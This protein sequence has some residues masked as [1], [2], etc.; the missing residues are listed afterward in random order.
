M[1][2]LLMIVS[3]ACTI[4]LANGSEHATG[5][6]AEE[7]LAPYERFVSAGA[8]LVIATPD[9]RPPQPDPWGLEPFFHY[10]QDDEDFMF[11]VFRSFAPDADDIRVTFTHFSELNLVVLRRVFLALVDAGL[12]RRAARQV[13]ESAAQRSWRAGSDFIDVL[14]DVREVTERLSPHRIRA[15]RD[16]VWGESSANAERAASVLAGIPGLQHPRRLDELTEEEILSCDGVFI[17]GG[18]AP[19]VDLADNPSMGRVL[20]LLHDAGKTIAALC[21]GPAALLSAPDSDG[22]WLFDGYKMTAFT[23][24]EEDQTQAGRTG[25]PWY[26]EDA[27]KN[28]GAVFDDGDAAWVSH[29]VIDRNLLTAQNPGSSEAGADILLGRLGV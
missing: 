11:S 2:K 1:T 4:G 26:L 9:G 15:I 19:M 13:L 8:D 25:M 28:R 10:P 16:E 20:K 23:N 21:H 24:E 5:Y 17:P 3:S 29:V 14:A 27:L 18:H 12:E 6:W 22:V 7:V